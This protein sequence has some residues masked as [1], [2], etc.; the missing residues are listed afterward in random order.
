MIYF[1]NA[2]S[3]LYNLDILK[4]IINDNSNNIYYSN[5]HS[6]N[7]ISLNTTNKIIEIR[8]KILNYVNASSE[9]YDCI[10]TSGTTHGLKIIG[11]Y[12]NWN[13]N[14]KFIY[15]IDNHTSVIGIREYALMKGSKIEVI[16]FINNKL[17]VISTFSDDNYKN[18]NSNNEY[19]NL[20]IMPAES[21]FSGK[22]YNRELVNQ[23]KEKYGNTIFL[24]DVAKY[25]STDKLNMSD[26]LID[27]VPISFYKIFGFP[28]GL[29]ALIV[30]KSITKYLT[31]TYYGGGTTLINS[32]NSNFHK[33]K[34]HFIEQYEDGSPNYVNII[35][36]DKLLDQTIDT[37][38]VKK[39]TFYFL[40]KIRELKHKN[41]K[42]VF[43]IYDININCDYEEFCKKH[44]SIIAFNLIR[45][46]G[47]YIDYKQVE[48][49][50]NSKN[51][52]VRTGS[53]CN[54][55]SCTKNLEIANNNKKIY[56][57]IP[58][59]TTDIANLNIDID[60]NKKSDNKISGV[61]RASFCQDNT[62]EDIDI[63]IKTI[64]DN[65]IF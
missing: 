34:S 21:N 59:I 14:N 40:Q 8:N 26:N 61:I 63:F 7:N 15:T 25:I 6:L 42:K 23:V 48:I 45:S 24:Y 56:S 46:T 35:Y 33:K 11:E 55:G 64:K 57:K 62:F 1:D 4:Y 18:T 41:E 29:G 9:V 54:N 47:K 65:Y 30:K 50:L 13:P 58:C 20:F 32:A 17:Q 5:P 38:K 36:L 16:D 31:K 51:I 19:S 22:I 12:F 60:N 28:T 53:L 52:Y 3:K 10:F 37:V 44:G 43:E 49:L 27:I 2:S 39:L